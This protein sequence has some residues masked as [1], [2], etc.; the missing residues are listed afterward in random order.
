MQFPYADHPIVVIVF[1]ILTLVILLQ[2]LNALPPIAVT[3]SF[4]TIS[5]CNAAPTSKNALSPA[6]DNDSTVAFFN[7]VHPLN[8]ECANV[9]P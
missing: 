1:G 6:S 8:S 9:L 4:I 7:P 2:P 5:P 3:P